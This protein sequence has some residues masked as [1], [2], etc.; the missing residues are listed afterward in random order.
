MYV[1][2]AMG[3]TIEELLQDFSRTAE[4][5]YSKP[6]F[7]EKLKSGKQLKIKYGVDVTAPFLHLGHAVNLRM[8]RKMQE[9]GHRVIFLIGDFTTRIGDPTGKSQTRP[10]IPQEEIE[11]NAKEFIKQV[12]RVLITDDKSVFEIRRNSEWFDTMPL[13][14]F[15]S[16]LSMV[17]HAR[18]ISRDMFQKRIQ[19]NT[20]IYMHELIYPILQ[21]YDSY[22]LESDLT[23]VGSDQLFNEMM[24]RFYQEKFGQ[25]PQVIITTK[26]TPGLD[27]KNKQ[28][29]SLNNYIAITDT[30]QDKFGKAM[31]L[32]DNL[33]IQW[34]E[35][36]TDVPIEQIR[37]YETL[38]QQNKI[39]PRDVK[40]QL[41]YEIT[42]YYDGEE[43][44]EKAKQ[45]FLKTFSEREFPN[46][47]PKIS[48]IP[49][50]Y[51]ALQIMKKILPNISNSERKR[52]ISQGSLR[53]NTNKIT[54][55]F[56]KITITPDKELKI[57]VGKRKFFRL[58]PDNYHSN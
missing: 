35:V 6:E 2:R 1:C 55:P 49:G 56:Q 47:A 18:L 19:E 42:K 13:S 53:I 25:K 46:D 45:W 5:Y 15:L 9:L 21:G 4:E 44:A 27:G 29:K 14:K 16:L 57:K 58:I 17:T 30:P 28:S 52:L 36:Y 50:E 22:M 34:L 24:G 20:E 33:I 31:S 23:I 43:E 10:Q 26:I 38:I 7:I 54:D 37:E 41:A 12:S 8:M 32:P 51:S 48:I 11:K 3:Y 39:N 40:L